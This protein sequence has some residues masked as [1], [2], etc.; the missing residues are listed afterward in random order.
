MED[1]VTLE[2]AGDLTGHNV[3]SPVRQA[4]GVGRVRAAPGN[5]VEMWGS[6]KLEGTEAGLQTIH[7]LQSN[8]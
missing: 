3:I 4:N 7:H 1:L 6:A 8:P 2:K 5:A